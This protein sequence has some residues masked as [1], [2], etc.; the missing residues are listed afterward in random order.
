[1][2]VIAGAL[3]P[4]PVAVDISTTYNTP[5]SCQI[6]EWK[7]MWN[8]SDEWRLDAYKIDKR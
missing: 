7:W 6:G 3:K 1:M 8:I 4:N 2:K 5:V